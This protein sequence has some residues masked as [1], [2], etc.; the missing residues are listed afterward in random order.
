MKLNLSFRR[1]AFRAALFLGVA[2]H[3]LRWKTEQQSRSHRIFIGGRLIRRR[4]HDASRKVSETNL[5]GG[6]S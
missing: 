1:D 2:L 4:R 3:I 6:V 5:G